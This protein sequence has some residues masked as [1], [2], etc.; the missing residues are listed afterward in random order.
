[1]QRQKAFNSLKPKK[2]YLTQSK[3]RIALFTN[4]YANHRI[5]QVI[6]KKY[7]IDRKLNPKEIRI[8]YFSK[9]AIP[10]ISRLS[11]FLNLPYKLLWEGI[12]LNKP[13]HMNKN[14]P[15]KK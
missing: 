11:H 3:T 15:E 5:A 2:K 9:N 14:V 1:M 8:K 4:S 12:M 6:K 7:K 13:S 10:E